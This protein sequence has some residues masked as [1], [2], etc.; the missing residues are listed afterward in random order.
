MFPRSLLPSLSSLP[1]SS[2]CN[3]SSFSLSTRARP[4]A[5]NED[6]A[7]PIP[8][9]PK[10]RSAIVT[11]SLSPTVTESPPWSPDLVASRLLRSRAVTKENVGDN[12]TTAP[13]L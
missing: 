11:T 9:P 1:C 13:A 12:A 2:L 7:L 10:G 4:D 5:T 6:A 8:T 3:L